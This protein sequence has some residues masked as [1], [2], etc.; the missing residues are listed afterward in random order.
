MSIRHLAKRVV[1]AVAATA[2]AG[3][4]VTMTF[5]APAGA[6]PANG[7]QVATAQAQAP[8]TAGQPFDSGQQIDVV[9][10]STCDDVGGVYSDCLFTP[11]TLVHVVECSAPN[12]VIPSSPSA[13]DGNTI[14]DASPEADGSMDYANDSTSGNL[15]TV[16]YLPDSY[17]LKEPSTGPQCGNT[18]AT[19]CILYIGDD[20]G[21]FTA[22]HV[23]SQ[24]FFVDPDPTDSGTI[25][26]GDGTPEVPMAIL[27]PMAAMGLLGGFL[28]VRRRRVA[29]T[30]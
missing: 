9:V 21:N 4:I 6:Q 23:W 17:T 11:T 19:E 20:Q 30:A 24:P 15:Y 8:Y 5:T 2:A 18:A 1:V 22:N 16:Y 28:I 14:G 26:P 29:R 25:N 10:P 12:G 27:L 3:A 13:C 7:A